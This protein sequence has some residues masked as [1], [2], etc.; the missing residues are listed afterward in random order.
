MKISEKFLLNFFY[1]KL[2][3]IF[4][5]FLIINTY[6]LMNQPSF[7]NQ[8]LINQSKNCIKEV[9]KNKCENLIL[10]IEQMQL[11]EYENGNFKCQSSLLGLQTEL[12]NAVISEK[13]YNLTDGI[14]I[15]N[16]I[17]YC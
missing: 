7:S 2:F 13:N 4:K 14:L 11:K 1:L 9:K 6:Y 12:I 15:P 10:E 17:K 16:V 8:Q 3:K 5:V